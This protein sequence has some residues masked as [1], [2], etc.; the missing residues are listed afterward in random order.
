MISSIQWIP[1]GVA[2][3]VP[4]KY[5]LSRAERELVE[6]MERQ[7]NIDAAGLA[8]KK[9]ERTTASEMKGGQDPG[10]R[11]SGLPDDLRMDEYSSDEDND[12]LAAGMAV[13]R[14]LVGKEP[15]PAHSE[16]DDGEEKGVD[17]EVDGDGSDDSDRDD[18]ESDD[19]LADA[20]DTR[21]YVSFATFFACVDHPLPDQ[22]FSLAFCRFHL[23]ANSCPS[24]WMVS[25]PWASVPL[26]T[27]LVVGRSTRT[28]TA[29]WKMSG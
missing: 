28:T 4:K 7:G 13:G 17:D 27:I 20:P 29:K 16:D 3:P 5:E 12:G 18:G 1:A 14:M 21:E 26:V 8:A 19:D 23:F 10:T 9:D 11:S 22:Y 25:K 6:L 24:T 2:A 15:S